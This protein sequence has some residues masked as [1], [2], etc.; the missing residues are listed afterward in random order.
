[1]RLIGL[2]AVLATAIAACTSEQPTPAVE[3]PPAKVDL[4]GVP[5][6]IRILVAPSRTHY[7]LDNDT[8]H[9]ATADLAAEFKTWLNAQGASP[10]FDVTLIE[11]A[12]DALIPDLLA[13]KGEIAA[14][15]LLTF[16]RDDQV[17]F[18]KPIVTGIR[19]LIVTGPKEKALVSLEDVGER[20][21]HVRRATDHYASLLRL[22]DQLKK[23]DRPPAKIVISNARTD[24]DLLE[25][26]NAGRIPATI[27]DD[28]V[29]NRWRKTLSG[30]TA[31]PDVAVSQDGSLAWVTRKD[32]PRL[33]EAL[34]AFFA[35]HRPTF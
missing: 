12:E 4:A 27:A 2:I 20:T 1:M 19:E 11:T 25:M 21:I 7:Y 22:N 3:K 13:G 9:G 17:A 6:H 31:N 34:N 8:P 30:L 28:Y 35:T 23:I 15:L 26:V 18:A 16:E 14:N 10:T 32:A 33:L 24:E 29:F 5:S